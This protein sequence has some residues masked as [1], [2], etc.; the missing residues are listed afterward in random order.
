[1]TDAKVCPKCSGKMAQGKM[2]KHNE[3][4]ARGQYMYDFAPDGEPGP[5]LSKVF[6]GKPVLTSRKSLAAF[7]CEQCGFVEFYGTAV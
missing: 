4:T 5:D 1:M 3:F 2:L 7:C 6:S